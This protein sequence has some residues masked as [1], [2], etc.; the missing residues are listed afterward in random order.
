MGTEV[1]KSQFKARALEYFRDVE[2]RN[3]REERATAGRLPQGP[4][5][6]HH[7]RHRAQVR[8]T[9]G[10]RRRKDQGLPTCAGDLVKQGEGNGC[11]TLSGKQRAAK[12]LALPALSASGVICNAELLYGCTSRIVN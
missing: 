11:P 10:Q 2:Q 1:S 3:R 8:R 9:T 5:R 4:G 6:P 7:R 12:K